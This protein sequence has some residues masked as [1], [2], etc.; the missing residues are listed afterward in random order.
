MRKLSENEIKQA[1]GGDGNDGQAELVA[2]GTIAGT[3]LSP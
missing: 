2:I 1:S 3:F